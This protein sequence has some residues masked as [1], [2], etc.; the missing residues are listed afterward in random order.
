MFGIFGN[1]EAAA[2]TVLGLHAL[3]H[4]G[5]EAAGVVTFDGRLFHNHRAL[6]LVGDH[7]SSEAVIAALP[8]HTA[9]GHVRYST[10]G[11]PLLRNVQP[12]FADFAFGGLAL[13]HNGN[14]TNALD[15]APR[16]GRA[17]LP[18]P[19][20]LGHR[21]D[22]PPDR[23]L[24]PAERGRAPDRRALAGP[25]RLC[26]GRALGQRALRRAR[27]ARRAPAGAGRS[28][29]RADPR[30]GDLRARH[31][32]RPLRARHRPGRSVH[33]DRRRQREHHPLP[34]AAAA[35]LHLRVRLLRAARQ[36]GRGPERLRNQKTHRRR[37][38][39]R[40]PRSRRHRGGGAR[41]PASRRRSA[42]PRPRACRSSSA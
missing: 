5:Q 40:A 12:L 24:A 28:R 33:S 6:G 14:L 13:G 22:H 37:A 31:H 11:A 18:V 16:A 38:R 3:Q 25:G 39:P 42:T 30:L 17:G 19:V 26:A 15:A 27:P 36:R 10:Q 20:D 34:A 7:F 41:L 35:L 8:G 23:A 9:I 29:W 2:H 1:E 21:G 32:G 4:R